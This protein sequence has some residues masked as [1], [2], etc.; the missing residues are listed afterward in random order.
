MYES[1]LNFGGDDVHIEIIKSNKLANIKL[2]LTLKKDI[3]DHLIVLHCRLIDV[4]VAVIVRYKDA[5][6][7]NIGA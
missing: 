5:R 4:N 3:K 2:F 1:P 6:I 7:I